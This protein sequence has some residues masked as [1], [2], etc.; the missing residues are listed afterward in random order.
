MSTARFRSCGVV[1]MAALLVLALPALAGPPGDAAGTEEHAAP[2]RTGLL[3]PAASSNRS[4]SHEYTD[5]TAVA[6]P[7]NGCPA[8]TTAVINV[9]D[10][11]T[12][13]DLDVGVW[14]EHTYRGDIEITLLGPDGVTA[15]SL[16]ADA[17]S[18]G[19]N[20]NVLFDDDALT[21]PDAANHAPPPPYYAVHWTPAA[22]LAVYNFTDAVGD[23][24]LQM[25]DDAGGDTGTLNQ[26]TLYFK[27]GLVAGP[28]AQ[29]AATCPLNDVQYDFQVVN[30]TGSDQAFTVAY[31]AGWP[32]A[33]PADTG[34]VPNG[35]AASL[36]L[37]HHAAG[38]GAGEADTVTVDVAGGGDSSSI[39]MTTSI[40]AVGGY[41]DVAIVPV[42]HEVR[43]H[44][45]VYWDGKLYKIGG[46]NGSAQAWLD[47]YDI[48]TDAWSAGADMPAARYYFDCAAIAAKIYCAGGYTTSGQSTL[49]IYDIA[50]DTWST[51]AAL[52]AYNY[53]YQGAALG[54]KYYVAGGYSAGAYVA[55]LW[56]YDP[57]ADTWD[58]TLAPMSVA[59]RSGAGEAIGGKLVVAGGQSGSSTY[60]DQVEAYDPA[61]DSWTALAPLPVVTWIRAADGVLGDRFLVLLGGYTADSTA[62]SYALLYDAVAD[63]WSELPAMPHLLYGA[64]AD[65]DGSHIWLASGR[66]YESGAFLYS[67]HTMRADPCEAS[68]GEDWGDAPQPTFATTFAATGAH[69][70]IVPGF[71][72]GATIDAEVDGQ[73]TAGAD[74]DD[75]NGV[76]DEDGVVFITPL[77]PGAS[78]TV[79]VNASAPMLLYAWF[80]FNA[81][82]DWD[83]AGEE[84]FSGQALAAGDNDLVFAVPA[85]A[86]QN[87]VIMTRFRATTQTAPV[88]PY[89]PASDGEVEDHAVM[90]I[91]VG[92][93]SLTVE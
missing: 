29:A 66:L 31:T 74:G 54:G 75:L 10:A 85:T 19:D 60:T 76:A 78:A 88:T 55:S 9:P 12:I 67:Y 81:D 70:T 52:P 37:F 77:D 22:P 86:P 35:T 3:L 79:R 15:V 1:S 59:R 90:L 21:A 68:G 43:D 26:W 32:V 14:M 18:G 16:I 57:V 71:H 53:R 93:Q 17:G 4:I 8:W 62:S 63:A 6:V 30:T 20:L 48:A 89:G 28:T 83:D 50:T 2:A 40:P 58:T 61:T 11:F 45:T 73:P 44:S 42:G 92:L 46:Y 72:L 7:D 84:V 33:G 64:E 87:T 82:G 65:G 25:C 36:S 23:W 80:D 38:L 5:T 69:H 13:A 39:S 34:V 24:T 41:T 47:I 27:T 49:Y 91:P 51:G 56:A